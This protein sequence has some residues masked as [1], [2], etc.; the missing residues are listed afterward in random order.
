MEHVLPDLPSRTI[1]F[2]V[3]KCLQGIFMRERVLLGDLCAVAYETTRDF[4]RAQFP[5][6]EGVPYCISSIHG[7]RDQAKV[8]PHIHTVVSLGIRDTEGVFHGAPETLDSSPLEE[9]FRRA[10]RG[11]C[12]PASDPLCPSHGSAGRLRRPSTWVH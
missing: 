8:H 2:T 4:L 11:S 3:P 5:G 6:V 1:V 12:A 10:G 7:A 9:L